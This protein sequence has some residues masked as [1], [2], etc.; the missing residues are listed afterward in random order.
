MLQ[1]KY[2]FI[3][4][5]LYTYSYNIYELNQQKS[6]LESNRFKILIIF[7][8]AAMEFIYKSTCIDLGVYIYGDL[9]NDGFI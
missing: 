8:S 9:Y 5:L 7:F 3:T 6:V 4:C 1:S 2:C